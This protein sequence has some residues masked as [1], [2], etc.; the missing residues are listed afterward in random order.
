MYNYAATK[1]TKSKKP[2]DSRYRFLVMPRFGL[3]LQKILDS[4][5]LRLSLRTAYTIGIKVLQVLEYVHSFGYIHA[6]IKASNLLLSSDIDDPLNAVHN[7]IWLVDYGLADRYFSNG[8]SDTGQIS[9][10]TPLVNRFIFCLPNFCHQKQ[11]NIVN[12]AK[13][14]EKRTME[15]S[16]FW[17]VILMSALFLAKMTWK[18]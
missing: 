12:I 8:T 13:T 1:T 14:R 6:D 16:S 15:R 2:E 10:V 7:Q 18:Y 17:L 3:D 11:K 9:F 4:K 5:E